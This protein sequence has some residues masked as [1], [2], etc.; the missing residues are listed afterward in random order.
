MPTLFRP[1]VPGPDLED[2][3][4]QGSGVQN[5]PAPSAPPTQQAAPEVNVAKPMSIS[6]TEATSENAAAPTGNGPKPTSSGRFQNLNA[7]IKANSGA[8][9]GN[10]VN[11]TLLSQGNEL[12]QNFS[13]AKQNYQESV[14]KARQR[15]DQ[16]LMSQVSQDPNAALK[17]EATLKKFTQ[18]RDA[19]YQGPNE[20][21]NDYKLRADAQNFSDLAGQTGTEQGRYG[22]LRQIY[23]NPTYSQGQQ[24][25]D[26]LL[27]QSNPDQLKQLQ[28]SKVMASQLQNKLDTTLGQARSYSTD[29]Q[30]EAAATRNQTRSALDNL[31]TGFDASMGDNVKKAIEEY[32]AKV[33]AKQLELGKGNI[34]SN[35]A[36]Q[37]GLINQL[38]QKNTPIY[39]LR[40]QDYL[41]A[42][43][44]FN[45]ADPNV[46]N[47]LKTQVAQSG[48]YSKL[49]ALGQLEG[50]LAQGGVSKILDT[51]SNPSQAGT[52]QNQNPFAF[53]TS[54][55]NQ[56]LAG[57]KG[58]YESKSGPIQGLI[59]Q[60]QNALNGPE[61]IA[62]R[63]NTSL[64]NAQ[65]A[66]E[67]AKMFGE[68]GLGP[69]VAKVTPGAFTDAD[70]IKQY[71][72]AEDNQILNRY[73]FENDKMKN[74]QTQLESLGRNYGINNMLNM[75]DA[76]QYTPIAGVGPNNPTTPT[77]PVGPS[78][79]ST[80]GEIPRNVKP[81]FPNDP[82]GPNGPVD[83][84]PGGGVLTAPVT[85][86]NR[87]APR[88]PVP[89][90]PVVDERIAKYG[91]IKPPVP[92][93]PRA[94]FNNILASP[95]SVATPIS[96]LVGTGPGRTPSISNPSSSDAEYIPSV[97]KTTPVVQPTPVAAPVVPINDHIIRPS[98]PGNTS[99]PG[100]P[101]DNIVR[102]GP[103]RPSPDEQYGQFTGVPENQPVRPILP[104]KSDYQITD[105]Y[106]RKPQGLLD[107]F[108][109]PPPSPWDESL[110]EQPQAPVPFSGLL[111]RFRGR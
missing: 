33:Q 56:D 105:P 51:Y 40:P 87:P 96:G 20:M 110:E 82:G 102:G 1:P 91:E 64:A 15:Y 4:P 65:K 74:A 34:T 66:F 103:Y 31:V 71:G 76:D 63:Y 92:D 10:R 45:T 73:Q 109:P 54:K 17:D 83:K 8:N 77:A 79:P 106:M 24:N 16:G 69:K 97:K 80:P 70:M 90:E 47:Q 12:Q 101:V 37:F 57:V 28:N 53:N 67:D 78:V 13:T 52:F 84:D 62:Q 38:G 44:Q 30:N 60:A 107:Q 59:G 19:Q 29:A 98:L 18:M 104:P 39:T 86:V 41:S 108:I 27:L 72:S 35:E 75:S 32:N 22:L 61:K 9:V 88:P 95:P 25:L 89:D 42:A 36:A 26:N 58:E 55:W 100:T 46:I 11:D 7:Y 81:S 111:N 2:N 14:D 48:D 6:G 94:P 21:D 43:Q 5:S 85:P 68:M 93:T 49:Q 23:N 99:T 3:E 50:G